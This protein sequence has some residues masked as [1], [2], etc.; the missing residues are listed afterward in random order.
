M[1]QYKW[2]SEKN[3]KLKLERKLGFEDV[4][5]SLI[6][7]GLLDI[8]EHPNQIDYSHQKIMIVEIVGYVHMIPFVEDE[9]Q[10]LLDYFE[11]NEPKSVSNLSDEIARFSSYAKEMTKKEKNI[12][13]RLTKMD[14]QLLKRKAE[15]M[16]MPYQTLTT[17]LIHRFVTGK[18]SLNA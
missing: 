8:V 3:E 9:E 13:L 17:S 4:E 2:N 15:E 14:W 7:G 6:D 1:K 11:E 18:I 16:G 5:A 10:F 12:N